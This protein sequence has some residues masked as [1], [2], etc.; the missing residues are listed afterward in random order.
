MARNPGERNLAEP[1]SITRH[2]RICHGSI[3][4]SRRRGS[5]DDQSASTQAGTTGGGLGA[6]AG[7]HL[8]GE[9]DTD[10]P[11]AAAELHSTI[12]NASR[13][14]C[15]PRQPKSTST[16]TQRDLFNSSSTDCGA[17]ADGSGHRSDGSCDDEPTTGCSAGASASASRCNSNGSAVSATGDAPTRGTESDGTCRECGIDGSDGTNDST[18]DA[19]PNDSARAGGSLRPT[20]SGRCIADGTDASSCLRSASERTCR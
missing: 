2:R 11:H 20:D 19:E 5:G 9:D 12:N 15:C 8:G 1:L 3:R 4:H 13:R 7:S 14:S 6:V 17:T 18:T 16:N 10:G